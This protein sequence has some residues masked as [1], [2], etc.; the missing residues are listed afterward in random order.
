MFENL[1]KLLLFFMILVIYLKIM[2][3]DLTHPTALAVHFGNVAA[4]RASGVMHMY[5]HNQMQ[6]QKRSA[7][8]QKVFALP[9]EDKNN[10]NK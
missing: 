4:E 3:V 8:R 5:V 6:T 7:P 1:P 9:Q 10:N 2:L